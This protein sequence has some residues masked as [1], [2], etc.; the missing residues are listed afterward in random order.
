MSKRVLCSFL[1]PLACFFM[2]SP[3]ISH[4]YGQ[5]F[6]I[7]SVELESNAPIVAT[8]AVVIKPAEQANKLDNR[9]Q[10]A[11]LSRHSSFLFNKNSRWTVVVRIP[12]ADF[13][14]G[15]ILSVS[16]KT[17][18]GTV[19]PGVVQALKQPELIVS[20]NVQCPHPDFENSEFLPS[21]LTEDGLRTVIASR[22]AKTE[23]IEKMLRDYLT[24]ERISKL[25][26]L[27]RK[28]NISYSKPITEDISIE[29]LAF[30]LSAIESQK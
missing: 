28:Y 9:T 7:K 25:H 4:A 18:D 29:E 26:K 3:L 10:S 30:R 24:K 5:Q 13:V 15:A 16:A 22:K 21:H 8:Y 11:N 20:P 19:I 12:L 6:T 23:V 14:E 17:A 1:L 27:E 2:P